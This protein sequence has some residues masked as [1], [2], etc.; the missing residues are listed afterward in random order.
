[1][2]RDLLLPR[3]D[4]ARTAALRELAGARLRVRTTT[5]WQSDART[6]VLMPVK[7]FDFLLAPI[8]GAIDGAVAGRSCRVGPGEALLVGAGVPH[9][10]RRARGCELVAACTLHLDLRDAGGAPLLQRWREPVLRC[11]PLWAEELARLHAVPDQGLRHRLAAL[12]LRAL[13]LAQPAPERLLAP[14]G[15]GRLAGLL[16]QL[17][18][19]C[20]DPWDEGRMAT[21]AGLSPAHLRA[22]FR[23]ELGCSPHRH[24][25]RLRLRRSG[26]RLQAGGTVAQAASAAGFASIRGFRLAFRREY[27]R[28]PGAWRLEE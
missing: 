13:L 12:H 15:S 8:A 22:R 25:V 1:M 17:D 9:Q 11:P 26:E 5:H 14:A 3:P 27:G 19:H 2:R 4:A 21:A 6:I 18:E 16:A 7:P 20:L 28:P 24:L 23:R 10:G